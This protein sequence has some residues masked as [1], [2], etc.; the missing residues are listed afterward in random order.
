M[1]QVLTR[2]L[3][4]QQLASKPHNWIIFQQISNAVNFLKNTSFPD[5]ETDRLCPVDIFLKIQQGLAEICIHNNQLL[6]TVCLYPIITHKT[7]TIMEIGTIYKN[8]FLCQELHLPT[9]SKDLIQAAQ[10]MGNQAG[11]T[12]LMA[13]IPSHC[14]KH[15]EQYIKAFINC[16]FREMSYQDQQEL[17][18]YL[19][20]YH[21]V[22]IGERV[23]LNDGI[24]LPIHSLFYDHSN[25]KELI[26]IS[27]L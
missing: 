18:P 20:L 12:K 15:N 22:E 17:A 27:N 24:T 9:R 6:W 10:T 23:T 8:K 1:N 25:H 14:A 5:L 26:L 11:A 2:S 16:G 3:L 7:L 13:V 21:T 19:A 4:Q